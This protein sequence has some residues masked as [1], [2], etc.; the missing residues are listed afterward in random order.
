MQQFVEVP[1]VVVVMAPRV[2]LALLHPGSPSPQDGHLVGLSEAH[3]EE[4]LACSGQAGSN[5]ED[6]APAQGLGNGTADGRSHGTSDQGGEH[7]Q[8][9]GRAALVRVE[10]VSNDGGIEDVRCDG[11]TS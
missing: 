9:H 5:P 7:D 2:P 3:E 8:A 6:L 10:H 1:V 4:N 11:K